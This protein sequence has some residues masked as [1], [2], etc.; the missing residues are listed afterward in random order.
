MRSKFDMTN[1]MV[2]LSHLRR[3]FTVED[4]DG[5]DEDT[6]DDDDIQV[7]VAN[8][9]QGPLTDSTSS[10]EC[11]PIEPKA[12]L[13][14]KFTNF[15]LFVKS[16]GNI[17]KRY[18]TTD[19][20]L[21]PISETITELDQMIRCR[22]M[23]SFE[24]LLDRYNISHSR[25]VGGRDQSLS[26]RNASTSVDNSHSDSS[27]VAKK[28]RKKKGKASADDVVTSGSNDMSVV[29]LK[30]EG[31]QQIKSKNS[32]KFKCKVCDISFNGFA[33]AL[34]HST[35]DEHSKIKFGDDLKGLDA[36][37]TI[38]SPNIG[39]CEVAI[40]RRRELKKISLTDKQEYVS[41]GIRLKDGFGTDAYI[42]STCDLKFKSIH[43]V[44]D[45]IESL[46]ADIENTENKPELKAVDNSV[47]LYVPKSPPLGQT[48]SKLDLK[49][50]NEGI[51]AT[52][53]GVD[54]KFYC[55]FCNIYFDCK[56]TAVLH[57][58]D[59]R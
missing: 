30:V 18:V 21:I 54:S 3:V 13:D 19:N 11:Q 7:L 46:A 49:L 52:D 4:T 25:G 48:L 43:E 42:C 20:G 14:P 50:K 59:T 16:I 15:T 32:F 5:T 2:R 37:F 56:K 1:Q 38:D 23:R 28:K 27:V 55:L 22:D 9:A 58:S 44:K 35:S 51:K 8:T 40:A 34:K 53:S 39:D 24:D 33:C 57:T 29:S 31:I 6:D 45:H 41:H 47:A 36:Q 26:G 10:P 12:K 17:D